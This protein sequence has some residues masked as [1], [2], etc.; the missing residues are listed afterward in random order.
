M[1]EHP[2]KN[3]EQLLEQIATAA[4][5]D[6]RRITAG[7]ILEAVGSRS[8]APLLIL[9]GALVT[10]PLSGI[11]L[12]P[13]TMALVVLLVSV[14]MV[15]GHRHFWLPHWL[16][17]RTLDRDAL[18]RALGGLQKPAIVVDRFL[19][20]RMNYLVSGPSQFLIALICLI[21]GATMPV[22]ELIPFSSS[23]AGA[24]LCAYG[25]ALVARDGLLALVAHALILM[26]I[27]ALLGIS[28]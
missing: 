18:L 9:T 11:P 21:I 17:S 4:D 10:S 25:L 2:P 6:D 7:D 3:F 27:V 1:S 16:L 19:Q 24:A 8:F 26:M 28:S 13:T 22:M 12:F 5:S 14:Q 23:V 20:P 15:I